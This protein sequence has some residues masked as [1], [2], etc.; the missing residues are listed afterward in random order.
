MPV[1]T[2]VVKS[3]AP[4]AR[5]EFMAAIAAR[6]AKFGIA[7]DDPAPAQIQGDVAIIAGNPYPKKIG[8][9][10]KK[11]LKRISQLGYQQTIEEIA[12]TWFNRFMALRYM[13][14][15][16]YLDHNYRVLSHPEGREQPEILQYAEHLDFPGLD[17]DKVIDLK[18]DGTKD[19]ELYRLL[20]VAQCNALSKS[21]PFLFEKI[22]DETELL[23][24]DNLLHTDSLIRQLVTSIDEDEWK[25]VEIIGWL[26][27][28]YIS[29][30]KDQVFASLKK[31]KK[32]TA[33]NIPAATQLF[34]PHWI[35]R[36]LVENSLGRLW[37]LNRPHSKLAEKMDYYIAPEEP[38][39][40]FLRISSPEEIKIC[41]PA[42]GSG[43]MLTYAFDLLYAVYEE[44][45]YSPSDIP[46][47]ILTHNLYGIEI[48]GRAGALSAFALIMKARG[49]QRRFFQHGV[50]PNICVLENVSFE[51]NELNDYMAE[52]GRDLF[53][54]DLRDTLHQFTNAKNYGSLI[55]PKLKDPTEVLR[56][57]EAK[58][59]EN[60]L[61]LRE[62]HQRVL[63]VLRMVDYLSPK[64]HVVVANPPYM[65]GTGM[66]GKLS[67]FVKEHFPDSKAD[68]MTCFM[69]R[70][71]RFISSKGYWAMINI[72]TWMFLSTFEKLRQDIIS[73]QFIVSL[74]HAGRGL[75]GPDFGAVA[76]IIS[77]N[78]PS[79]LPKAVYRRLFEKQVDVRAPKV[80]EDL[81]LD[82]GYRRYLANQDDFLS[83]PGSPIA[84]WIS[85]DLRD[86]FKSAPKLESII[87]ARQGLS[88]SDNPRFIRQWWEVN[89]NKCGKIG[90]KREDYLDGTLHWAPYNKGGEFRRWYGNIEHVLWWKHDGKTISDLKP[91]SVMRSQTHYFR[92][93]VSWLSYTVSR[94]S[95][96]SYEPGFVFD[97]S[98]HSAFAENAE[99]LSAALCFGNSKAFEVIATVINPTV[100]FHAGNFMNAPL[101]PVSKSH[102][103]E[104]SCAAVALSKSDWDAYETSWDFTSLPLISPDH[105]TTTLETTYAALRTHW[106]RMIDEMQRLEEE[107]NRIFIDAYGLQDE[108][109]PDV[110]LEEITLTCNP[111][112]RYGGKK[113]EEELEQLLLAD[114]MRELL[115][116]A[117][118]CIM[119][120][121]SLAEAGTDLCPS[122]Q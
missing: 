46:E 43:H 67:D 39:T 47:K 91:K 25:D 22:D 77:K 82:A 59:F 40:D 87:D 100:N 5:R 112:Y 33:E 88:T 28:F 121:Y 106:H 79:N 92:E 80:I 61:F 35:V 111:A 57:L 37:L 75:F 94:N 65:G 84:Y 96:R 17:K 119:G 11:L 89:I 14:L 2:S 72:P 105:H 7:G 23:L 42:C 56:Q 95:F 36:Y 115:S 4:K 13:E 118:G 51:D 113:T 18:L 26:Y 16:G 103:H 55:I 93:S 101:V 31:G 90:L 71:E 15:N 73:K 104:T 66:N 34:T 107:N 6:A 44:E 86:V 97:T 68:L 99:S 19:A 69:E 48:D 63:T 60:N 41:D 74:V 120:R 114:T 116:Y 53:T 81:F 30:K 29:E 76:F 64:Y 21:M 27:Q 108:L 10:H 98:A 62:V 49:V 117:V 45:G 54:A 110:P 109:A 9:Q 122:W 52:V 8:E 24:P 78:K 20:L 83:I 85:S 38:E 58:R 70:S 102:T 1:N 3:Y 12:Y 50:I 32:I